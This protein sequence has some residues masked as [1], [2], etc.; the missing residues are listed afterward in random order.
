MES[1]K[2]QTGTTLFAILADPASSEAWNRFVDR[3][4]PKIL[5]WCKAQGLQQA[6]AED[7]TQEVLTRFAKV[8][9]KFN[10]DRSKTGFRAWLR[11]VTKNALCDVVND[12]R[13]ARASDGGSPSAILAIEAAD[14]LERELESEFDR[15]LFDQ[16][17]NMVRTRVAPTTWQAFEL[18]AIQGKSGKEAAAA[19]N[20]TVAA[21]YMAKS[22]VSQ[23]LADKI[24]ELEP[25]S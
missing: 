14:S 24:R 16:A 5:L 9:R 25:S 6:D 7:I 1:T 13:R 11:M 21:V 2:S 19:L 20:V 8:A 4:G 12:L 17:T 15:E 3:Y 22:R 23:M 18:L 10:Y